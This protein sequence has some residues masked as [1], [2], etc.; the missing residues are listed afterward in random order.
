MEVF[1]SLSFGIRRATPHAGPIGKSCQADGSLQPRSIPSRN[2]D[3]FAKLPPEALKTFARNRVNLAGSS[4]GVRLGLRQRAFNRCEDLGLIVK[5]QSDG[6][7]LNL[8]AEGGR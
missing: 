5:T 1:I 8:I 3:P 7:N 4:K 2:R 6:E